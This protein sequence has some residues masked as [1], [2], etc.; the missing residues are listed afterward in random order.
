MSKSAAEM[1]VE[2]VIRRVRDALI[3]IE[4]RYR[5][6]GRSVTEL[7]IEELADR[8]T[9]V[10]P[11]PSP[12]NEKIG[13]FYRSEQVAR[14]L[15]V[16]RQAVNERVRKH[17][18]LALR[19]TDETLVYPTFQFDGRQLL[20]GLKSVLAEFRHKDIDR[21]AVAGWLV[22]PTAALADA[23]PLDV[24]QTGADLEGVRQL[25]RDTLGR[26]IQ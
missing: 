9:A 22:S 8:M 11:L 15:G 20:P 10:V 21:W 14:I 23:S 13:P 5:A 1:T 24:V 17:A 7:G 6:R 16:S 2:R 12:V 19:T 25:A 26:W 4:E 3:D 18:I